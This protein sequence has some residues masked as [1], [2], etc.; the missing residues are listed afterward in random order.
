MQGRR[1]EEDRDVDNVT[2]TMLVAAMNPRVLSDNPLKRLS[3]AY[4]M[5]RFTTNG[6]W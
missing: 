6:W 1:G 2:D 5:W 4:A 3:T